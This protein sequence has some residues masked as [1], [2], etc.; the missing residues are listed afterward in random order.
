MDGCH[1]IIMLSTF[2]SGKTNTLQ[3]LNKTLLKYNS[4]DLVLKTKCIKISFI[5]EKRMF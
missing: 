4:Y 1:F 2:N 5:L 3:I